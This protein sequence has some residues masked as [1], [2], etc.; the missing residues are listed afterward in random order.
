[1]P[2]RSIFS[3]A[4]ACNGISGRDQAS[5]AGDKSSVFVSPLTLNTLTVIFSATFSFDVNHSP[6]A[7]DCNTCLAAVLPACAFSCTS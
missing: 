3:I 4:F 7:Q 2:S 6:S 1:M 5:G